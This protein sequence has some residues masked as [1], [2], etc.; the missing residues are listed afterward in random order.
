MRN[1]RAYGYLSK[2]RPVEYSSGRKSIFCPVQAK[3]NKTLTFFLLY[4][5]IS[6]GISPV[7]IG[8]YSRLECC[9]GLPCNI[10]IL[11]AADE[12]HDYGSYC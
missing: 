7:A 5:K 9:S 3:M 4:R 1:V 2:A 10:T 8:G 11:L 6:L 12:E